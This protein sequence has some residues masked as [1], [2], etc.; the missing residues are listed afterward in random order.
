MF[1]DFPGG[2]VFKNPFYKARDTGSIPGQGIVPH[3]AEQLSPFVLQLLK[4]RIS[5]AQ[6]PQV[7]SLRVITR[8]PE[9]Q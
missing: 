2:P 6:A 9:A 5:G 7:L 8:E 1:R 3:A 4:S